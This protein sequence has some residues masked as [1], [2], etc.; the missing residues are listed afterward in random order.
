VLDGGGVR[1]RSERGES[2]MEALK[3]AWEVRAGVIPGQAMPEYTKRWLYTSK[4]REEDEAHGS[5]I[6]YHA[7]FSKMRAEAVDYYIQISMPNL[8][9]WAELTFIW[10]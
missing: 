7:T 6:S 10:Y 3:A 5:E 9:N 4:M 2:L 8:N 1:F